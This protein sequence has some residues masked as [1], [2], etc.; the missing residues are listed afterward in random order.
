[1]DRT[2]HDLTDKNEPFGSI[3]FV[4]LGDFCEVLLVIPRGSHVDIIFASIKN[5]YL[6]EFV[7]VF[8]LSENMRAG[9]VV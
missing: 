3:V 4:M 8:R 6:W 9:D 5:S 7:E 1:M 2:L